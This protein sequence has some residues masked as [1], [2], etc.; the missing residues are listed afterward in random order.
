MD[1][2][3]LVLV[4]LVHWAEMVWIPR[5]VSLSRLACLLQLEVAVVGQ[6]VD[7]ASVDLASADLAS[8]GLAF[9]GHILAF[10]GQILVAA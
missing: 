2:Q 8:V 9:V 3:S 4:W 5:L 7:L 6:V 1:V 10:V